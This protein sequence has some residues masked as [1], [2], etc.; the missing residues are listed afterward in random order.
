MKFDIRNTKI[1]HL[2]AF[3]IIKK[4]FIIATILFL[5]SSCVKQSDFVFNSYNGMKIKSASLSELG[6]ELKFSATNNSCSALKIKKSYVELVNDNDVSICKINIEEP[7]KI[8]KG[9]SDYRLPLKIEVRGGVLGASRVIKYLNKSPNN[10][11]ANGTLKF[12]HGIFSQKKRIEKM[13]ISYFQN[14]LDQI[15]TK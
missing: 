15:K 4:I 7:L 8:V 3:G 11:Y 13:P 14:A 6:V 12:R 9:T 2:I 1:K 5:N 10:I